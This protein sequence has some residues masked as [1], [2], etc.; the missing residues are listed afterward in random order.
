MPK[1]KCF[2]GEET[3]DL[4]QLKTEWSTE[5]RVNPDREAAH[6]L[7][8]S[9]KENELQ[10]QK[11]YAVEIRGTPEELRTFE[12]VRQTHNIQQNLPDIEMWILLLLDRLL[13]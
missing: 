12:G 13:N 1:T 5:S 6:T 8:I 10:S 3:Y 7:F 9:V 2:P 4:V 11:E